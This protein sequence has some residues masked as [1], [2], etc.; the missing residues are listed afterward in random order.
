MPYSRRRMSQNPPKSE[1]HEIT[2]SNLGQNASTI[3]TI[4]LA[5]AVPNPAAA[6]EVDVGSHIRSLYFETNLNGVDNSGVVQVFHWSIIKAPSGDP[7]WDI[8][9]SVYNTT[10]KRFIIKRGMEMLPEIPLGSGGTVQTK[11]I[12]VVKIPRIYQ[13]M[14]DADQFILTYKST[15]SSGINY[16][17]IVIY[18]E[19]K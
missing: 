3:Q 5:T 15:S 13:R 2:W 17:G 16:C 1:K 6:T 9:P 4:V 7:A 19:Q 18:R 14:A 11:R 12:F 8:D 10:K